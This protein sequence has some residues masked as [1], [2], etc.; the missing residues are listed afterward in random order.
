MKQAFDFAADAEICAIGWRHDLQVEDFVRADD[1]A[2]GLAFT[3]VAVDQRPE[4]TR[5]LVAGF[6]HGSCVFIFR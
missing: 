5:Y 2:V 4:R 1:D 6:G 3:A